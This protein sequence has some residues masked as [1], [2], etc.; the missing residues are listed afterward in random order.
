ME[1]LKT[2]IK[3]G[4]KANGQKIVFEHGEYPGIIIGGRATNLDNFSEIDDHFM[5]DLVKFLLPDESM[6]PRSAKPVESVLNISNNFKFRVLIGIAP[7]PWVYLYFPGQDDLAEQDLRGK[8]IVNSEFTQAHT[9]EPGLSGVFSLS[10]V[11]PVPKTSPIS[12][13][14]IA[15]NVDGHMSAQKPPLSESPSAQA[16]AGEPM[17]P[18]GFNLSAPDENSSLDFSMGL[19]ND[20]SSLPNFNSDENSP[21]IGADEGALSSSIDTSGDENASSIDDQNGGPGA[22]ADSMFQLSFSGTEDIKEP[23][24][25]DDLGVSSE[26]MSS[27]NGENPEN[28]A[29][30][31]GL[32]S[33]EDNINFSLDFDG[34]AFDSVD[35]SSGHDSEEKKPSRENIGLG[36]IPAAID[37]SNLGVSVVDFEK[38]VTEPNAENQ[39]AEMSENLIPVQITPEKLSQVAP[40]KA[41]QNTSPH[42]SNPEKKVTTESPKINA[43]IQPSLQS[44]VPTSTSHEPEEVYTFTFGADDGTAPVQVKE[45]KIDAIL[46]DMISKK[47]S[48]LHLTIDQPI[49]Y[50]VDGEMMR[51]G[52]SPVKAE[53][54]KEL[55]LPIMPD[56]NI[57]EFSLDSDTDFAY[58]IMGVGRFRVNMFRDRNGVGS[59]M[60]HIPS[61][62]LTMEQ[63]ALPAIFKKFCYLSKGLVVVTGPTGSG[64]STTLAAMIDHINKARKT[65]IITVEDPIEFVHPQQ[66]SLLNQRE[67]G[68]HTKSFTRALRAA[69]REDPDIVLIGEMRDLETVAIAIETAETG[70]LVFG[71]L[72]TNTAVSTVDRIIDQF[73]TDQQEQIRMMLASSLKGVISQTLLKKKGSGRVAAHEILVVN[74]AVAAM[75]REGKNHMV[76]NHMATQKSEGNVLLN[77]ALLNLMESGKVEPIE[78]YIKAID[79]KDLVEKAKRKNIVIN[80]DLQEKPAA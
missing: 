9:I 13:P 24:S 10:S 68:R 72:H 5:S 51:I 40:S 76:A 47:A 73:P 4:I 61:N 59:V 18:E 65:H 45:P 27:I 56:R 30:E 32:A 46:K 57:K 63:L 2:I 19:T 8:N 26:F 23:S 48:D 25:S 54:M 62:I 78:A 71:T 3:Y 77:D 37:T 70:H 43:H 14:D 42:Q 64:K 16:I 36:A 50:R 20:A 69:L 21:A 39:N 79:K 74:D 35:V 75:I 11:P 12:S 29:G 15:A 49:M 80:I 31:S 17:P 53:L 66:N 34:K 58:E 33:S 1:H 44:Q 60:R 22:G 6:R 28:L 52:D 38:Q 55:L 7:K 67:M 41:V